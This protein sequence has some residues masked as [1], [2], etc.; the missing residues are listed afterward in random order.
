MVVM[1]AGVGERSVAVFS[2]RA[3]RLVEGEGMGANIQQASTRAP[4]ASR[5][6]TR[7]FNEVLL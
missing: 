4:A 5:T 7:V 1:R 2:M 6:R 3:L